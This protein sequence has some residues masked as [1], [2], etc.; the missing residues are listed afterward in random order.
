M[1]ADDDYKSM[2]VANLFEDETEW[3]NM[4]RLVFLPNAAFSGFID[5]S[6]F[7]ILKENPNFN[8]FDLDI[9]IEKFGRYVESNFVLQTRTDGKD[10]FE[11]V[12]LKSC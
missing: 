1:L 9:D 7:D 3:L 11:F 8:G 10:K 5:N 4:T 6:R 2:K 12:P